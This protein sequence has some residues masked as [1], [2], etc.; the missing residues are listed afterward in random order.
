LGTIL[1]KPWIKRLLNF[2]YANGPAKNILLIEADSPV[3]LINGNP[4][5]LSTSNAVGPMAPR[6]AF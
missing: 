5:F 2:V 6:S 3:F 4:V 1:I